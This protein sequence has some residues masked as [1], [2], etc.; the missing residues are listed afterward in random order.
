MS[1]LTYQNFILV[2][3]PGAGH[4]YYYG[5]YTIRPQLIGYRHFYHAFFRNRL[6]GGSETFLGAVDICARHE[7]IT[8]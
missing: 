7:L 4:N 2:Y 8:R 5:R 3:E 6:L 1:K